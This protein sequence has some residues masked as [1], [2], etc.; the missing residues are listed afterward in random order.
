MRSLTYRKGRLRHEVEVGV[1]GVERDR[2]CE[3]E[4]RLEE[5]HDKLRTYLTLP[6]TLG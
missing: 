1:L 6:S 2:E 3:G 4:E 5:Y